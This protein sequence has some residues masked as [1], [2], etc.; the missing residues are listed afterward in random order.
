VAGALVTFGLLF[1]IPL[2]LQLVRGHG[3]LGTG[4]RLLPPLAGLLAG[5]LAGARRG[6][7]WRPVPATAAPSPPAC[8]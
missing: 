3:T 4:L 5:L 8:P 1:V 7:G 2:Y 6:S